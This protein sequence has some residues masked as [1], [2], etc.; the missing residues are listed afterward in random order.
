MIKFPLFKVHVDKHQAMKNIEAVFNSGYINE[1]NEVTQLTLELSRILSVKNIALYNSCTSCITTALKLANI[2]EGSYVI[3]T[4]MTCVATNT[5][6]LNFSMNLAWYD[7]EPDTGM[8]SLKTISDTVEKMRLNEQHV[9]AV[10]IVAWAGTPP[11]ELDKIYDY[12]NSKNI[13][14]ILDAAHAF[15]A[16]FRDKQIHEYADYT[17]YSFQA[18]KHFTTGDGGALICKNNKDHARS[19]KLKWFGYDRDLVKT[20]AGDWKGQQWDADLDEAGFKFNMNNVAAA[21]GLS[22][23]SDINNRVNRH[24]NNAKLINE[25]LIEKQNTMRVVNVESHVNSS[26]WVYTVIVDAKI[27]DP[28]VQ[29][30]KSKGVDAGLVHIPNNRYTAFKK[31]ESATELTGLER[32]ADTQFSI[33]CGWWMYENDIVEMSKIIRNCC[34]EI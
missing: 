23:I 31:I 3:S 8:P 17:C 18:I 13:K 14:L 25:Y 7:I 30:L 6:V 10:I 20:D 11:N 16:T 22:Q 29:K 28:L 33:P 26:R 4:P 1:G 27:R 5:P 32:F 24:R 15:G 9:G 19:K 34:N 2:D 12:C 21:I